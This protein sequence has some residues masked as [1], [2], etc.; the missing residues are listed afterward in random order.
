MFEFLCPFL[1]FFVKHFIFLFFFSS[2]FI[3]Y[4]LFFKNISSLPFHLIINLIFARFC[5]IIMYFS[6]LLDLWFEAVGTR[7][8]DA[9]KW[10]RVSLLHTLSRLWCRHKHYKR[11]KFKDKSFIKYY[12]GDGDYAC[13]SRR[14]VNQMTFLGKWTLVFCNWLYITHTWHRQAHNYIYTVRCTFMQVHVHMQAVNYIYTLYDKCSV[15]YLYIYCRVVR[16]RPIS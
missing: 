3:D 9:V 2:L 14:A 12:S 11:L 6:L 13:R 16:G 4:H 1:F 15:I 7:A 10:R 5:Q 8:V